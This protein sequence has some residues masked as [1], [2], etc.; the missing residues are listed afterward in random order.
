MDNAFPKT[1]PI[2]IKIMTGLNQLFLFLNEGGS[3]QFSVFWDL[4][5]RATFQDRNC[6]VLND[7]GIF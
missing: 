3:K 1:T 4:E 2:K 6:S 7:W 5:L